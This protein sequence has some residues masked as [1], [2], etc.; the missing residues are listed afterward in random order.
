MI[1]RCEVEM[2]VESVAESAREPQNKFGATVRCVVV[3]DSMFGIDVHDEQES[4]VFRVDGVNCRYKD[5]LLRQ[6]VNN[7][8]DRSV[9]A[10]GQKLLNKV[11]RYRVP[12]VGRSRKRLQEPIWFVPRGLATLA[13]DA[14]V[15][16]QFDERME[17]L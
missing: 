17:P 11:H 15:A 2:H 8:E 13:C 16:I 14:G 4:E 7:D 5:A 1:T 10:R 12:G 6:A 3:G 9:A